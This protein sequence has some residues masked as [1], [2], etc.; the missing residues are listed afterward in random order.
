MSDYKKL[1]T[2]SQQNLNYQNFLIKDG[3]KYIRKIQIMEKILQYIIDVIQ[4]V[5]NLS[6]IMMDIS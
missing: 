4:L 2:C 6:V 3:L 1:Q 5:T